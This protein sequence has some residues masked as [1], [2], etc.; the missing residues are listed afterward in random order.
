MARAENLVEYSLLEFCV[1]EHLNAIAP[2]TMAV[3]D[4]IKV[5]IE[6]YPEGQVEWFD[7][8]FSQDGSVEGSRKV[9]FSRELYIERDDF[10]EDP[11]RSSTASSPVR[12]SAC[13]MPTMSRA[14]T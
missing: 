12:K 9:P 5:V 6:N 3:L 10:R 8:P 11:R 7:M 2:R 4:P 13:V 14:R 1:R